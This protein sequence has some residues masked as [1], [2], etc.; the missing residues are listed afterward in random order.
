M[1]YRSHKDIGTTAF[2]S[3][4]LAP[5]VSWDFDVDE[6]GGV[7]LMFTGTDGDTL[8]GS[9]DALPEAVVDACREQGSRVVVVNDRPMTAFKAELSRYVGAM[10]STPGTNVR[11]LFHTLLRDDEGVSSDAALGLEAALRI[12]HDGSETVY[13]PHDCDLNTLAWFRRVEIGSSTFAEPT[14]SETLSEITSDT[15]DLATALAV[16]VPTDDAPLYHCANYVKRV[17]RAVKRAG[18]ERCRLAWRVGKVA[19]RV[20]ELKP[21]GNADGGVTWEDLCE[22][23]FECSYKTIENYIDLFE[24]FP[25]EDEAAKFTLNE[26]YGLIKAKKDSSGGGGAETGGVDDNGGG[27]GP[28]ARPDAMGT[29]A[30][31]NRLASM[32]KQLDEFPEKLK[33]VV[34]DHLDLND[35]DEHSRGSAL[36]YLTMLS[37]LCSIAKALPEA[38]RAVLDVCGDVEALVHASRSSQK[39][40]VVTTIRDSLASFTEAMRGLVASGG[41]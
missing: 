5:R 31:R 40:T 41:R 6:D 7:L 18:Y 29:D 34:D 9:L 30:L 12:G 32:A 19:K 8:L 35:A 27:G 20:K 23:K 37:H 39:D 11:V 16:P 1:K 10:L 26:A 2:T 3:L 17:H 21:H 15:V 28:P 13:L 4:R 14:I 25:S 22:E 36:L 33:S 24:F 38:A